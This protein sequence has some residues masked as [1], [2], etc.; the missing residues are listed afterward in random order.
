VLLK[1]A[2]AVTHKGSSCT[3]WQSNG[4]YLHVEWV[5]PGVTDWMML[6]LLLLGIMLAS[7]MAVLLSLAR[8]T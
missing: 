5:Q 6:L 7:C 1:W 8:L 2:T 4:Q 3:Y